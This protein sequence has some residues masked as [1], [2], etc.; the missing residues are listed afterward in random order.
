MINKAH[1]V[2]DKHCAHDAKLILMIFRFIAF[3][4][5]REGVSHTLD[6]QDDSF[7]FA[8]E[9]YKSKTAKAAREALQYENWTE[10]WISDGRILDC[11][12]KAVKCDENLIYLIQRTA[13]LHK[14]DPDHSD[15]NPQAARVL[16]DIYKSEG[17]GAEAAALDEAVGVLGRYYD[18]ISY[19]FF[20][21]DPK[22]FLPV[23]PGNFENSLESV[24]IKH[25]LSDQCSWEK[26]HK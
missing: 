13:L 14:I 25:D 22:R 3:I 15:Y 18:I 2:Y 23:S 17:A 26:Y 7:Y 1:D 20:I 16:Y 8:N 10:E 6:F 12:R 21:K 11:V 4:K 24:G 9:N 19:L 5:T